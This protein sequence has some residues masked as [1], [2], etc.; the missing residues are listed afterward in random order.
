MRS[1]I[2]IAVF[3][4][5]VIENII[6]Q[7]LCLRY[8]RPAVVWT[9]ALPVGNGRMGAMV[10]GGIDCDE[11]QLNESTFWGGGPHRN[12]NP[13]ALN[14]LQE[15]RRLVFEGKNMEAQ[16]LI[17][18]T[19]LS[20]RNGMPYLT[21]GSLFIERPLV[22]TT[23]V[24]AYRRTLDIGRAITTTTWTEGDVDY[25]TEVLA[26][27]TTGVI[28]VHLT[29]SRPEQ[30]TFC[31]RLRSP[32]PTF[33]THTDGRC[34]IATA[35]G[36]EHE[37]VPAALRMETQVAV[38]LQD[39]S[40]TLTDSMLIV[41]AAT[42][43]TLYIAAATNYV[44]YHDTSAS[45]HDRVSKL[46]IA[47]MR[48]SWKHLEREHIRLYRHYYNRV[49][50]DLGHNLE[51]E[52][53]DTDER[54]RRFVSSPSD[55]SLLTLLFQYGRYLLIGCS[56][57]GGQAATL[58]GLWNKDVL[59]PWD[60]K[61]TINI[62]THMNYWPA[63]VTNLS[64]M[65]GPLF[66]LIED[67]SQTGRET[68]RTMYGAKGWCAHHN[69]DIWRTTGMVDGAFWGAWPHGGAWLTT[70]L[71]EHYLFTGDLT[72]LRHIYP[73]LRGA[74]DFYRTFMVRHPHYE[75]LVTCPSVSPE[76][77]PG[78]ENNKVAA[79]VAGP[80]MDTEI[81]RDVFTQTLETAQILGIDS[82][83]Q[84]TLRHILK[85]LPPFKIGQYGQLQEW[86]EDEDRPD[87]HHRH[88]S[89]LY[90]LYPS[91]Q[92]SAFR[93]P[94]VWRAC[95]VT[96]THRGDEATGWSMGWKINL[97]ARLFDGD[98]AYRLIRSFVR[99]LPS[100]AVRRDYPDGRLYTNLFD[101]HPP[102]QIDGNFGFTA[103]IA[104]MLL[105]SHDG[106]I[107]L[108]PALPQ[109]WR[110]GTVRGLRARG[111]YEVDM[112]WREGRLFKVSIVPQWHDGPV[113]IRSSVHLKECR[114]VNFYPDFGIYEYEVEGKV[115]RKITIE[116]CD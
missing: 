36:Q 56:Q 35:N 40:Q 64:E 32:L 60:S 81:V 50:L 22:N 89:H 109:E 99:L 104:E 96:L 93:T 98:H 74:T 27:L 84:D 48:L 53:L 44:N 1:K 85:E 75:W 31:L 28:V 43:A 20:G 24:T 61:Y 76:H 72:F 29:A 39:G 42:E 55:L 52:K 110:D 5:F 37:G 105:Q 51:A 90:G 14:A 112:V 13:A 30:L 108:L 2:I 34:F 66:S 95:R 106:A 91:H 15:V 78:G 73:I 116:A 97:W 4:F 107:H 88:V 8:S 79:V 49:S 33:S 114:L 46:L 10:Y 26:S 9:D 80:T 45:E 71:W 77:G 18:R 17:N 65:A 102:F 70:H 100:D 92:I 16:Q 94:D 6:A 57:P 3:F 103:G 83:F 25:K 62:N 113:R 59:A 7:D 87:D 111:G 67:L 58:Q 69:T 63:E 101:A 68:A 86:L 82:T 11:L 54:L 47:S 19:S 12:D 38:R 41:K 23:A 21:L 115:G